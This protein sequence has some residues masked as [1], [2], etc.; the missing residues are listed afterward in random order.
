M[1]KK[2]RKAAAVLKAAQLVAK[3]RIAL[4]SV[5]VALTVAVSE[6]KEECRKSSVAPM[7]F[8]KGRYGEY[9]AFEIT[10]EKK[11]CWRVR[12]Q[13]YTRGFI[14]NVERRF[15]SWYAARVWCLLHVKTA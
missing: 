3:K 12:M 4:A 7:K 14:E 15:K 9:D 11:G 2:E 6:K 8:P 10:K 13:D 5:P 1:N